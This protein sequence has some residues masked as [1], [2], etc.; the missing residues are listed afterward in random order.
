M[1]PIGEIAIRA[2]TDPNNPPV[3][4]R[5]IPSP[6]MSLEPGLSCRNMSMTIEIGAV[7]IDFTWYPLTDQVD[8]DTA[9]REE[10]CP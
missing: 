9:L 5:R 1:R 10:R 2:P 3:R 4:N 8:C 7:R 6:G